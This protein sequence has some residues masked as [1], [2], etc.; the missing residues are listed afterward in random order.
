MARYPQM[1]PHI[2]RPCRTIQREKFV[3]AYIA[4]GNIRQAAMKAGMSR[5]T[6]GQGSRL[7]REPET[8]ALL[9]HYR[10]ELMS[11]LELSAE[12]VL[13]E[14]MKIG[15]ANMQDYAYADEEGNPVFDYA[16]VS[17]DQAAALAE[18]QVD[19]KVLST[20]RAK[21]ANENGD[22]S[23]PAVL[24]RRIKFKLHDKRQA[25]VDLGKHL[26]LFAEDAPRD[27]SVGVNVMIK[28]A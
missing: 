26:G 27:I 24:S 3:L 6:A 2:K 9:A 22:A 28:N 7:L 14:L 20:P 16:S 4:M 12:M 10:S 19:E 25:L 21:V 5:S 15:F 11:K 1:N 18:I 17:R 13:R 23:A 8:R